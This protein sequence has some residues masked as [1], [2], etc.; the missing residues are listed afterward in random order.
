MFSFCINLGSVG[1]VFIGMDN[2][3][4]HQRPHVHAKIKNGRVSIAVDS[5]EIM[6]RKPKHFDTRTLTEIKNWVI[7][8]K[9]CLKLIYQNIQNIK[10][11]H[12]FEPLINAMN[13]YQ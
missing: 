10:S 13:K 9:E 11:S 3:A 6:H 1:N 8:K 7:P 12:D 4:N 2:H 5:G